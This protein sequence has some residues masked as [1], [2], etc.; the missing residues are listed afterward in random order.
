MQYTEEQIAEL[1]DNAPEEIR[2]A[3]SSQE[4]LDA[5][6]GFQTEYHLQMDIVGKIGES[7]RNS[8]LGLIGPQDFFNELVQSGMD[9]AAAQQ[10][11][12]ELN[13][14]IFLPLQERMKGKGGI[15]I[16][17][18]PTQQAPQ[19]TGPM[20]VQVPP[21][22]PPRPA[23]VPMPSYAPPPPPP[24]ISAI[25]AQELAHASLPMNPSPHELAVRVSPPAERPIREQAP[26]VPD[27]APEQFRAAPP[28]TSISQPTFIAKNPLP[29]TAS[30]QADGPK[31]QATVRT[32][33]ADMRAM[34][35]GRHP[36]PEP[37]VPPN[38]PGQ[39]PITPAPMPT[40][41]M[42]VPPMSPPPPRETTYTRPYMPS[43]PTATPSNIPAV[44]KSGI[45][46]YREPVDS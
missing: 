31:L 37:Y 46:P 15:P 6:V 11:L 7:V 26:M 10:V 13:T 12:T 22:T 27:A 24:S 19:K 20:W 4:L 34:H 8:L 2:E 39:E 14:K 21:S 28:P 44:K 43:P 9:A 23:T 42:P 5:I 41:S 17:K 32:M 30:Q 33:S 36:E 38:L 35:D 40:R 18:A 45:D 1:F 29:P 3:L 16:P 25:G